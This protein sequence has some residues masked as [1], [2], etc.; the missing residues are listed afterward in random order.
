MQPLHPYGSVKRPFQSRPVDR[1]HSYRNTPFVATTDYQ[2]NFVDY[3]P[4]RPHLY[5]P[6]NQ[7]EFGETWVCGE[8][9][10]STASTTALG[11]THAGGHPNSL[12]RVSFGGRQPPFGKTNKSVIHAQ[13]LNL[14]SHYQSRSKAEYC[15]DEEQSP[16]ANFRS[17]LRGIDH[18]VVQRLKT[19]KEIGDGTTA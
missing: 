17:R 16:S 3:K 9:K 10:V 14:P 5:R 18:R 8:D 1:N 15:P 11:G 13:M 2:A 19:S 7:I 12:Y 4:K 6:D